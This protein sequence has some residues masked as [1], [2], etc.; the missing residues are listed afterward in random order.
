[1]M[2]K[3]VASSSL[4]NSKNALFA[5]A[6]SLIQ[7]NTSRSC[8]RHVFSLPDSHPKASNNT[9]RQRAVGELRHMRD[10]WDVRVMVVC[11]MKNVIFVC[12]KIPTSLLRQ[13]M[14]PARKQV[15]LFEETSLLMVRKAYVIT[16]EHKRQHSGVD[17][18][19]MLMHR[20]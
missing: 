17:A 20:S 14:E 2:R 7:I 5:T 19:T 1:M 6:V 10:L 18:R 4:A 11:L 12:L 15:N 8:R 9:V 3:I 16:Q 13:L